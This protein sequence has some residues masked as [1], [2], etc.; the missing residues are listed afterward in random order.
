MIIR[1]EAAVRARV[2]V[3]ARNRC[4]YCQSS[5]RYVLGWLA[6][7]HIVC[8]TLLTPNPRL[9]SVHPCNPKPTSKRRS[10]AI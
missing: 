7:D 4:G 10:L 5:Q 9:D 8:G 1:P 2:R 6:I 3:A